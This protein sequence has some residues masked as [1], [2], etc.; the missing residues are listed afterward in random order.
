MKCYIYLHFQIL[1]SDKFNSWD[2]QTPSRSHRLGVWNIIIGMCIVVPLNSYTCVSCLIYLSLTLL[3]ISDK[4]QDLKLWKKHFIKY[5]RLHSFSIPFECKGWDAKSSKE[6]ASACSFP[7]KIILK[8][9]NLWMNVYLFST[10]DLCKDSW[11]S[12]LGK[13]VFCIFGVNWWGGFLRM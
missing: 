8:I 13:P 2:F 11:F 7:R 9:L 1:F 3:R 12:L 10:P 4:G 5:K 6:T